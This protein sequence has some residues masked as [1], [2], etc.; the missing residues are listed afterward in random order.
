MD[1]SA[2]ISLPN[3]SSRAV[4]CARASSADSIG[5]N[6]N[7]AGKSGNSLRT[8]RTICDS[9]VSAVSRPS[10]VSW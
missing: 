1:F 6:D 4:S 8:V 5:R 3:A 10:S 2:A 9:Q 7:A